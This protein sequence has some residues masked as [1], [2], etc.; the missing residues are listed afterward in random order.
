MDAAGRE[1]TATGLLLLD[2]KLPVGDFLDLGELLDLC[3]VAL[4]SL[5]DESFPGEDWSRFGI[6]D[7]IAAVFASA[8]HKERQ[9]VS[10]QNFSKAILWLEANGKLI[11]HPCCR[12]SANCGLV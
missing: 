1:A 8:E 10:A 11:K 6:S 3:S 9:P 2:V 5:L 4:V 7:M 12:D